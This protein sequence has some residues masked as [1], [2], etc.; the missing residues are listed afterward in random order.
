MDYHF[1]R[2][3]NYEELVK[4]CTAISTANASICRYVVYGKS[5]Q[6]RDLFLLEITDFS[7][8]EPITKPAQ[9]IDAN[10]HSIEVTAG[11]AALNLIQHLVSN[12]YNQDPIVVHA[13]ESRTFYIVPRVN[14]DG[15][16]AALS[17]TNPQY[18]RSSVRKWPYD[19][20]SFPGFKE[21]D[22]DGDGHIRR[23]R[24]KDDHGAWC[25]HPLEKRVMIPIDH[26]MSPYYHGKQV[27]RYRVLSEG[28][29]DNYDGFTIPTPAKICSLDLNRNF[30]AGWGKDIPGSGDHALSEVEI[31]SMVKAM[32]ERVNICGANAY[33]TSGGVLL[34]PS[35]T[36]SDSDLPQSDVYVWKEILGPLGVDKTGLPLH[37]CFED[38]TL[39]KKELMSGAADDYC[40]EHLGIF[41]FTTEFYDIIYEAT[42]K[43]ASTKSWYYGPT[44]DDELA[45]CQWADVNCPQSYVDWKIF[46]HPQLGEVEIGGY[47][48]FNLITN[49]PLHMLKKQIQ[50]HA[51]FAVQ[52][53]RNNSWIHLPLPPLAQF[54][55]PP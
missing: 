15:V 7:T 45:I 23:M 33:H 19:G 34:R 47:D 50:G 37:S 36:K 24:I 28:L 48:A 40:Y 16:E 2:Y 8:G 22:V 9:W 49:P 35:S 6:G 39:D 29:I 38:F 1:D 21:M 18:F 5:H 27:Q 25:E 44:V 12:Y 14:P 41:S 42:G 17:S 53:V 55:L 46:Q 30:P 4:W 51:E 54:S 11:V 13:L 10:I 26:K 20:K 32:A 3:L 52:Q 31:Y 43:R